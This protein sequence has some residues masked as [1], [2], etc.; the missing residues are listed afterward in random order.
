MKRSLKSLAVILLMSVVVFSCKKDKD[1]PEEEPTRKELITNKWKITDVRTGGTSILLLVPTLSCITD[2]I[3][4]F[5]S[6]ETFTM[7]E[8]ANV[9][10]PA[11]EGSGTWSLVENDTKV[12]LL[13][14]E[15]EDS[16]V[17]APITELTTTTLKISYYFE[18][19]PIPGNYEIVLQKQ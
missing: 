9:C 12:K 17:L 13:F 4:T 10:S 6:N 16:E 14:S 3:V 11:F 19:V 2:N 8:G 7:E 1:D 18:D 5:K 15:P